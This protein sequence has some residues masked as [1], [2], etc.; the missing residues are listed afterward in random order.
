MKFILSAGIASALLLLSCFPKD[1]KEQMAQAV[2]KSQVIMA[3]EQFQRTL[4][5][6]EMFK[7]R[8]GYYPDSLNEIT[9]VSAFDSSYFRSVEY[10][11]WADKYELNLKVIPAGF[12]PYPLA[13]WQGLGCYQSNVMDLTVLEFIKNRTTPTDSSEADSVEAP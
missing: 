12:E 3:K 5:N 1:M 13:F 8:H 6:I 9:F 10:S 7:L 2:Q 11:R 4:T